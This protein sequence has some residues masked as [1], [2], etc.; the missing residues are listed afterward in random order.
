MNKTYLTKILCTVMCVLLVATSVVMLVGC[1]EEKV[2]SSKAQLHLLLFNGGDGREWL[3]NAVALFEERYANTAFEDGKVGVQV[4]IDDGKEGIYDSQNCVDA[5]HLA[6]NDIF[7]T[8]ISY[9]Y[10]LGKG[11]LMDITDIVKEKYDSVDLDGDGVAELCSIEDKMDST[12]KNFFCIDGKYYG[13]RYMSYIDGITYDVDLFEE[14]GFYFLSNGQ[15]SQAGEFQ[16]HVYTGRGTLSAGADGEEGTWDDGLPVTWEQMRQLISHIRDCG[17]IPFTWDN[18]HVYQRQNFFEAVW[19]S[20]EGANNYNLNYS[21]NG[22]YNGT[23]INVGGEY[24]SEVAVT[25]STGWKIAAQNGK[26]AAITAIKDITA[27]ATTSSQAGTYYNKANSHTDAQTRYVK[28]NTSRR[29]TGLNFPI[30]MLIESSY[31]QNEAKATFDELGSQLDS[32]Y[33][34]LNH[35]YGYMPMPRFIGTDNV[36]DQLN[37]ELVLSGACGYSAFINNFTQ[38]EQVAKEFYKFIYSNEILSMSTGITGNYRGVKTVLADSDKAKMSY[39]QYLCYTLQNENTSVNRSLPADK[40]FAVGAQPV[41]EG[42]YY[43]IYDST[44]ARLGDLFDYFIANQAV[45]TETVFGNY[46]RFNASNWSVN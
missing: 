16:D 42:W 5:M 25:P 33:S 44:N 30:A 31:W 17:V 4:W 2:D 38:H 6:N 29:T 35:R 14:K 10:A 41:M 9:P 28:S 43:T 36:P 40:R 23:A 18:A 8:N 26:Y 45:A 3:D 15:F 32:K 22:T 1:N 27:A 24:L 11:A 19:A 7:F 13:S 37:T 46:L 34:L 12:S 39:Y 20:Y 21:M